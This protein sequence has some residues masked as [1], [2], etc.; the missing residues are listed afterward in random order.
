MNEQNLSTL[1]SHLLKE[2]EITGF[3][4]NTIRSLVPYIDKIINLI[5][6]SYHNI[7]SINQE[8]VEDP[9]IPDYLKICFEIN[10]LG[11]SN[12]ILEDE[13]KFYALFFKTI[14]EEQQQFF[15]ITYNIS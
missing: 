5:H 6:D 9:E 4:N 11:K 14:P 3:D 12:R 15:T 1:S 2:D 7:V 10:L 8:V 13:E